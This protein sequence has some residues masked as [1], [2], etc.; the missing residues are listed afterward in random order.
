MGKLREG[1]KVTNGIKERR[2]VLRDEG[3]NKLCPI[4]IKDLLPLQLIETRMG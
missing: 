4:N 2:N 3:N 1:H